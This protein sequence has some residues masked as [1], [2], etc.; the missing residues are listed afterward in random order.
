MPRTRT[1][2]QV[3]G[4][5]DLISQKNPPGAETPLGDNVVVQSSHTVGAPEP[6]LLHVGNYAFKTLKTCEYLKTVRSH[7]YR[8]LKSCE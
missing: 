2:H 8:I 5:K 3:Q 1:I 7:V 6:K 4:L